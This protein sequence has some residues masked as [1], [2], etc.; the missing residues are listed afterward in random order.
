MNNLFS[1]SGTAG[2]VEEPDSGQSKQ[3]KQEN[4]S[5]S[6]FQEFMNDPNKME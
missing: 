5:T 6:F 1:Q 3:M 4:I 2:G